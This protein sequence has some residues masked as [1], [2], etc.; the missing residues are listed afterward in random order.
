MDI[1]SSCDRYNPY[2][3]DLLLL[4]Y[5]ASALVSY[6]YAKSTRHFIAIFGAYRVLAPPRE[7]VWLRLRFRERR[8]RRMLLE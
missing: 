1:P 7:R 3:V 8:R 5:M 4:K 2:P 6:A